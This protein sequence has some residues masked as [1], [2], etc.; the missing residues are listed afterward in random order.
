MLVVG[1][2]GESVKFVEKSFGRKQ[3]KS[4]LVVKTGRN[5]EKR[6]LPDGKTK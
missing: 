5:K 4:A 3:L 1:Q 2:V 6:G